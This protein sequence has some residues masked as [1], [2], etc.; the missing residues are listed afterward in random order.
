M[1]SHGGYTI[2]RQA[3]YDWEDIAALGDTYFLASDGKIEWKIRI[4]CKVQVFLQDFLSV[5]QF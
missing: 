4:D 1:T 3:G 2:V 5:L